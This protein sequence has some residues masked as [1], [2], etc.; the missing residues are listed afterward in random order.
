MRYLTKYLIS[1]LIIKIKRYVKM[2]EKDLFV[3]FV[4]NKIDYISD[5]TDV[6]TLAT[7]KMTN[8][9]EN[10]GESYYIK[11]HKYHMYE[12]LSTELPIK[13]D[14]T[15]LLRFF[16]FNNMMLEGFRYWMTDDK[17]FCCIENLAKTAKKRFIVLTYK[18]KLI[19][20]SIT[21]STGLY[22]ENM[23]K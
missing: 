2:I 17:S 6:N 22:R 3:R 23:V 10:C 1:L 15:K 19:K 11:I 7:F 14:H 16:Q 20:N 9:I 12:A 18:G 5:G 8:P 4:N 13:V 21:T